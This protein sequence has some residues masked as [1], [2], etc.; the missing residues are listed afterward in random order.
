MNA[1]AMDGFV[2]ALTQKTLNNEVDWKSLIELRETTEGSNRA[3]Y[4]TVFETEFHSVLFL[5]SFY[6][7][8]PSSGYVYLI[9]ETFESGYDGS[10]ISGINIYIQKDASSKVYKLIVDQGQIYRLENAILDS[11]TNEDEEIQTFIDSFF[12]N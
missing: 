9:N 8:L 1:L 4:Y 2:Q 5:K 7:F 10:V 11:R 12:D 6:C 3:L